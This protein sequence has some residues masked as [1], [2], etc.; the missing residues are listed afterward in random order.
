[1]FFT[2]GRLSKKCCSATAVFRRALS[3]RP[4]SLPPFLPAISRRRGG[5]GLCYRVRRST[6]RRSTCSAGSQP[7]ISGEWKGT[8]WSTAC[9]VFCPFLPGRREREKVTLREFG[10]FFFARNNQYHHAQAPSKV[11]C[12][13]NFARCRPATASRTTSISWRRLSCARPTT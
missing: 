6:F 4:P 12:P 7:P 11:F 10:P 3:A 8:H 13:V 1:M 5:R 2:V 9:F